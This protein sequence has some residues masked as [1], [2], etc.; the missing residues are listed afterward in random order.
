MHLLGKAKSECNGDRHDDGDLLGDGEGESREK[1]SLALLARD[2]GAEP[3]LAGS[4]DHA[5][6][7]GH[8]NASESEGGD[9]VHE[10]VAT[11]AETEY[12]GKEVGHETVEHVV[13]SADTSSAETAE[14]ATKSVKVT[15]RGL[16]AGG[17]GL[18]LD[19]GNLNVLVGH[20]LG[21]HHVSLLLEW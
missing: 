21:R 7:P 1:E 20:G 6:G 15:D 17:D 13:D 10:S 19:D 3:R 12:T 5:V 14:E 4:C 2:H 8:V 9:D 16:D 18:V 11:H